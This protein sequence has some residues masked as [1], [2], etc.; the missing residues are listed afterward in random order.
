MS[1]PIHLQNIELLFQH[2]LHP[3]WNGD[4]N[5]LFNRK[6]IHDYYINLKAPN[7]PDDF[8]HLSRAEMVKK[9]KQQQEQLHGSEKMIKHLI[10]VH[11]QDSKVIMKLLWNFEKHLDTHVQRR[12]PL[13]T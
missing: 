5:S 1:I 10:D 11:S 13:S 6:D 7:K 2:Y 3:A 4:C 12:M 9:L 8:E